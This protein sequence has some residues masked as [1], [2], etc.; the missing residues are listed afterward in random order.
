MWVCTSVDADSHKYT[1]VSALGTAAFGWQGV[2]EDALEYTISDGTI[3][4]TVTLANG[5]TSL[6]LTT[7][8]YQNSGKVAF[9]QA[10]NGIKVQHADHWSTDWYLEE[11]EN[12]ETQ[13]SLEDAR[14][15]AKRHKIGGDCL[16]YQRT[17]D[18][19][20][21]GIWFGISLLLSIGGVVL[22]Y[23]E[24]NSYLKAV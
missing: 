18:M 12:P 15:I 20:Y 6:A 4:G 2:A 24:E 16:I 9:N 13:I 7:E 11:V 3:A 21:L 14:A 22:V 19:R 1:F 5:T 23:K 17:P 8:A 10:S